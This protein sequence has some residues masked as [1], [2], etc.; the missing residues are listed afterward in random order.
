MHLIGSEYKKNSAA[1]KSWKQL[2]IVKGQAR[3]SVD[4][5]VYHWRHRRLKRVVSLLKTRFNQD[6]DFPSG[7]GGGNAIFRCGLGQGMSRHKFKMWEEYPCILYMSQVRLAQRVV[8]CNH[9][10]ISQ[11]QHCIKALRGNVTSCMRNRI[12]IRKALW[13]WKYWREVY[14]VNRYV[15]MLLCVGFADIFLHLNSFA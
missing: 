9:W 2:A 12:Q 4:T 13:F 1:V 6:I 8:S 11:L 5:A 15:M 7:E 10:E 14:A 3:L